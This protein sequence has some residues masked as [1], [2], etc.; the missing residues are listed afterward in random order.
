MSSA[1]KSQLNFRMPSKAVL[2]DPTGEKRLLRKTFLK[3]QWM[4]SRDFTKEELETLVDHTIDAYRPRQVCRYWLR[5]FEIEELKPPFR[6]K[7]V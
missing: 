7:R 1:Q 6:R 4:L 3:H 2:D 5:K